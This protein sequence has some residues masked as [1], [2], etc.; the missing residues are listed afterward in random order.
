MRL[1]LL[2]RYWPV[3][4]DLVT[5]F[6]AFSTPTMLILRIQESIPVTAVVG[7]D[8]GRQTVT[9]AVEKQRMLNGGSSSPALS[10]LSVTTSLF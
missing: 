7:M 1:E 8:G 4:E 6:D 5:I 9:K 3:T 10:F 2:T